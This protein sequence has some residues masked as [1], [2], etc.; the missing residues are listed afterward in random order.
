LLIGNS[1]LLIGNSGLLIDN[2]ELLI[3]NSGL[4]TIGYYLGLLIDTSGLY[5]SPHLSVEARSAE[6][7]RCGDWHSPY[8]AN[9]INKNAAVF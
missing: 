1:G 3:G 8:Y 9:A 5:Q 4:L 7:L 6:R 2:S